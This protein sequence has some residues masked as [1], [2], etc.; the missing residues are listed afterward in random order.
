MLLS[1]TERKRV[2][3][4]FRRHTREPASRVRHI[5]GYS[6]EIGAVL[7]RYQMKCIYLPGMSV[8]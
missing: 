4:L 8:K 6:S 7:G 1:N 5:R 3:R 2:L